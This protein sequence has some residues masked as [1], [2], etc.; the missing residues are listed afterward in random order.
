[1]RRAAMGV[2]RLLRELPLSLRELIGLALSEVGGGSAELL[3][4]LEAFLRG[5]LVSLLAEEGVREEVAEAVVASGFDRVDQAWAR[6]ETLAQVL[7]EDPELVRTVHTSYRRAKR[8][9]L[10]GECAAEG[11]VEEALLATLRR[12]TEA[13]EE[14]SRE[15]RWREVLV[16]LGGFSEPLRAFFDQLLVMDPDP[17]VQ[18]RRRAL[19]A[20]V[21]ETMAVFADFEVLP[22]TLFPDAEKV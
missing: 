6:A 20:G 17:K 4:Q 9:A 8:L 7:R 15:G 2:L 19:L 3:G 12:V 22:V 5:R 10:P 11:E 16:S 14:L 21:A 1:M 18:G 13:V